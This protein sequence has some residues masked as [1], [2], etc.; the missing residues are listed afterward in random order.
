MGA[1]R[2]LI[3]LK[4]NRFGDGVVFIRQNQVM[5]SFGL[6]NRFKQTDNVDSERF[7]GERF[8]SVCSDVILSGFIGLECAFPRLFTQRAI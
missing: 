8:N 2:S 7:N 1:L 6:I 4:V 3:P 5:G